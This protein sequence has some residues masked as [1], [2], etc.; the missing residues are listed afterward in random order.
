MKWIVLEENPMPD[1]YIA[2]MAAEADRILQLEKK[3]CSVF[4]S[5]DKAMERARELR[6]KYK[7]PSIR[8]FQQEGI[9]ALV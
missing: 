8:L 9:S 6:Q 5:C 1:N 3:Q 7:V 4:D 2:I